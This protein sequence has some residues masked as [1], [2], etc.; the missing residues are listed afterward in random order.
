MAETHTVESITEI[1]NTVAAVREE[2]LRD[3]FGRICQ[4][5][6]GTISRLEARVDALETH[7]R[8]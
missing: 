1:A 4:V 2:Q 3:E 8:H 6:L 5:I 7:L